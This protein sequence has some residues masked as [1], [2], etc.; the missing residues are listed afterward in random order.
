VSDSQKALATI[1]DPYTPDRVALIK[2]MVCVGASDDELRMFVVQCQRTRLDPFS[3]QIYAIKRWDSRQKKEV[4]AVQ[5]SIDGF[6][7]IAERT[8][9]YEG[10][11]P[12]LWCGT[13]G[14]WC[15][16]WLRDE[17]PSAAKVGVYRRGFREPATAVATSRSYCQMTREGKPAAMWAKMPD[18]M[19]A[20]CAEALALRKAFPQELSGLYTAEEMGQAESR[21]V[22]T[23][24]I[25]PPQTEDEANAMPAPPRKANLTAEQLEANERIVEDFRD[26]VDDIKL[27]SNDPGDLNALVPKFDELN[28]HPDHVRRLCAPRVW[29][30]LS[31]CGKAKAWPADRKSRKWLAPGE[32]APDGVK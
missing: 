16:V 23:G 15:D 29:K 1:D 4:M 12:P 26:M 24:P 25:A 6:R 14:V 17:P 7:L 13:D 9:E 8:G 20:K 22:A 18:V 10:Q 32:V 27:H 21:P 28:N 11:T 3:R 2:S 31:D 19:L 30:M 5:V